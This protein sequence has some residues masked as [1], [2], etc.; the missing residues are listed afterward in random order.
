MVQSRKEGGIRARHR[1]HEQRAI[2]KQVARLATRFRNQQA[3]MTCGAVS[4]T[5]CGVDVRFVVGADR[6][7]GANLSP[8]QG[9]GENFGKAWR[10]GDKSAKRALLPGT[11]S[12]NQ[13][14]A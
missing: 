9:R 2:E 4:S 5:V 7:I 13:Q 12:V 8:A 6:V 14:A 11:C 10:D 1:A 3:A